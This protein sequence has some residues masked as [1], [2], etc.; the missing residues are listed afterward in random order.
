VV[1]GQVGHQV[2]VRSVPKLAVRALGLVNPTLRELGET[3]Y[4]FGEPFVLDV[5]KYQTTFGTAGTPL[6]DA[7]AATLAWYRTRS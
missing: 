4:Q 7:I 6:S 2:G 3:Y 5:T 1:A